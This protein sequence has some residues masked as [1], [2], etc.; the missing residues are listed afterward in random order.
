MAD[1]FD[2]IYGGNPDNEKPQL[3]THGLTATLNLV[4]RGEFTDVQVK[5]FWN[6]DSLAGA[7]F[8]ALVALIN[9]TPSL[10]GKLLV[11]S[12]LESAGIAVEIGAITTKAQ[13]KNAAGIT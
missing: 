5:T 1:I 6:M 7:D 13:Y 10:E 8:D 4:S 12:N 11:L 9:G 2:R 3:N